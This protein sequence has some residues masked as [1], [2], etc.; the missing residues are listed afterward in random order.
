MMR[1]ELRTPLFYSKIEELPSLIPK[2]SEFLLCFNV[3]P[4]QSNN[5][6]PDSN[7]FLENLAYIGEKSTSNPP[8]E[9]IRNDAEN[10]VILPAGCYLFSQHR[11]DAALNK[12][13]WLDMAI[14]QQK[15]GLWERHKPGNLLYVRYLHEDGAIVTQV[16]RA[17]N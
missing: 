5:F 10:V 12:E 9:I 17:L 11:G 14:E 2:N 6:E 4:L 7:T 1:L 13:E 3:N 15:D 8:C 16:F